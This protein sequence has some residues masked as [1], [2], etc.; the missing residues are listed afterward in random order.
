MRRIIW[1]E[2]GSMNVDLTPEEMSRI[3]QWAETNNL[4]DPV[5]AAVHHKMLRFLANF[6]PQAY[7]DDPQA[8]AQKWKAPL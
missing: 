5:T 2:G 3:L 7:Q 4:T 8:A 1:Y 6:K